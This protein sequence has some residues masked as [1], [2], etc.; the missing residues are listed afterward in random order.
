MP[1]K[2]RILY[3]IYVS[4]PVLAP[5]TFPFPPAHGKSRGEEEEGERPKREDGRGGQVRYTRAA[6][7]LDVCMDMIH[8]LTHK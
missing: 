6:P 1:S 2:N 5:D 4:S 3:R 8:L 7:E